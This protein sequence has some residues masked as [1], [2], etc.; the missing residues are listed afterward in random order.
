MESKIMLV[1]Y[2]N[3]C[4]PYKDKERQVHYPIVG[5]AFLGA[6]DTTKIRFYFDRIGN[7]STTWV[8]VAKLPNG[9]QGSRVLTTAYDSELGENYAE[10]E[11]SNWYTQAKGDVFIALQGYQ[12]GVQYSYDSETELYEI[13]GT[14]TI[15]TTGSIKLAIN[16]APV[17]DSPDYND[18][19][20]T[21]QEI[22]AALGDKLDVLSGIV[23]V[24]NINFETI[25][26]YEDGQMFFSLHD[27]QLYKKVSGFFEL[28]KD[29]RLQTGTLSQ[30]SYVP[31]L[32]SAF[33][34][35]S[36]GIIT[37][38]DGDYAG[39]YLFF[40][41]R[42]G[43][44]MYYPTFVCLNTG[45]IIWSTAGYGGSST[46]ATILSNSQKFEW[47]S[48]SQV[49]SALALKAD[50]SDT[51]TKSQ[52]DDLI[53]SVKQNEF[54]VVSELPEE[55]EEGIIYLIPIDP[56]DTSLGYEQYIWE[57]SENDYIYLGTTNLDL[58]NYYTKDQTDT[59]L[60][61]K[62][63]SSDVYT[64]SQTYSKTETDN[65]LATK[66]DVSNKTT[67]LSGS[68][69][70][71]QYPSAKVVYDQLATKENVANKVVSV[72]ASST[73][74][75]YPS[76]KCVY[77]IEQNLM[78]V[79]EGKCKTLIIRY[80]TTA[81][82]TDLS[83]QLYKKVDGTSFTDLTDFNSYVGERTIAN[84]SFNSQSNGLI[85][86]NYYI[87][88]E[89]L[90][91]YR[92]SDLPSIFNAGDIILVVETDVPDR[93]VSFIYST[94]VILN[95]LET[96]K[97]DLS[98]YATID[99]GFNVINASDIVNNT[100]TDA[101]YTLLT[102]GKPTLIKG[103]FSSLN[104]PLM[105]CTSIESNNAISAVL[106]GENQYRQTQFLK[107]SINTTTKLISYFNYNGIKLSYQGKLI[108]SEKAFPDYP[109][110][111]GTF[112]LKQVNGT[113]AWKGEEVLTQAEYD[114]LVSGG[115][116]DADTFYFIEE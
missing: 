83:A 92:D 38:S 37:I 62:A 115:T 102:N 14:P 27:K 22:L 7:A 113:L 45:R 46:L 3:D 69:T 104:S 72:S 91:V 86:S 48:K 43:N 67:T 65:L 44:V 78:E 90:I 74:T 55:G 17:G 8:S 31:I 18:E 26:N 112:V 80:S 25:A 41:M 56:S 4:L 10:L 61:Q 40:Y 79:A 39:R 76:A 95:K 6:S 63:N 32:M 109:S 50:K 84:A 11:L 42:S 108:L 94:G 16:Y 101:Q 64:K 54:Q 88:G 13:Y 21:Y 28:Y 19:F 68:S 33:S 70:D 1:F 12:G 9:K 66:E 53:G 106:I 59:L 51:Y 93:W 36:T 116:V 49:D 30:S 15:Q 71:T 89:D 2:G 75:Q 73:D 85:L 82:A 111:T 29:T 20:T 5:N 87:I 81:P 100:L 98:G 47:Y 58:R 107:I 105:F 114:A 96:T 57:E 97:V 99:Q 35:D 24:N 103:T 60:S 77:D 52:V 34:G 110:N 23:V